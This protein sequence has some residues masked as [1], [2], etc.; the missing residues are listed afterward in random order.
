M[1]GMSQLAAPISS[2]GVVLSQPVSS[3]TASTGLPRMASSTSMLARLRVSMAVGR[4]FDSPLENTGN[5][6]GKPPA[7]EMP[8]LTCSAILRKWALQGVSSDQVLQMPTIGRPSN[9]WSGMPWFFIQLRYMK[10]FLSAEPN[11]SAER[12]FFW[13]HGKFDQRRGAREVTEALQQAEHEQ[14]RADDDARPPRAQRAVEGDQ[15]LDDPEHQH[16]EQRAGDIAHAAGEQGAADDHRRDGVELE[17]HGVQAV[18]REHVEGEDDAGQ[19]R[20]EAREGV[21]ADQGAAHRQA[22]QQGRMLAAANGVHGATEGRAVGDEDRGQQ[23]A[24]GDRRAQ[25]DRG[26]APDGNA[27]L[28]DLGVELVGD[29]DRIDADQVAQAAREEHA[30]QRDDEGLQPVALDQ[31]AHEGAEGGAHGEHERDHDRRAPAVLLDQRGRHHGGECDHRAHRKIDAAGEDHEGHADGDDDQ[32]GVVDQQ[33]E[34]DLGREEAVVEH[35]AQR[36]DEHEQR[37]WSRPA[38]GTWD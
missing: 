34:E 16:A 31:Q 28:R 10:P 24:D 18:A 14:Q 37:R 20:A 4:R 12:N 1:A 15:G 30:G 23:H 13:G 27:D 33:V 36:G 2:A 26:L 9:S 17:A 25:R 11:H 3:T 19:R 6:T 5:S 38:A 7:S 35:R 8:R 32:E 29:A 21:D 22:H